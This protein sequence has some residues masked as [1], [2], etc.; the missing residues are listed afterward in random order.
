VG[1]ARVTVVPAARPASLPAD[2]VPEFCT[3][4]AIK[5]MSPSA[6]RLP[7]FRMPAVEVPLKCSVAL[8]RNSFSSDS[9][10]VVATRL[11]TLTVAVLVKR[12]PSGLSNKTVPP[13]GPRCPTVDPSAPAMVEPPLPA[14]TRLS[15][16]E[17]APAAPL[18]SKTVL[19]PLAMLNVLQLMI[20]VLLDW[21]IVNKLPDGA[22]DAE[23]VATRPPAGLATSD[24]ARQMRKKAATKLTFFILFLR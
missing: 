10:K 7:W 20:A 24:G 22:M 16:A 9:P 11:P 5:N 4:C 14:L 2:R 17:L 6:V 8:F 15:T 13:T 1:W 23:P 18:N 3:V 12:M 21:L 19:S